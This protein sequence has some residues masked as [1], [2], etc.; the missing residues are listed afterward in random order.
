LKVK[1]IT[2]NNPLFL[3]LAYKLDD[4]IELVNSEIYIK[5]NEK[6]LKYRDQWLVYR[7]GTDHKPKLQGKY[8]DVFSAIHKARI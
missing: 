6:Y 8:E 4:R 3:K 5:P 7:M 2:S 1:A